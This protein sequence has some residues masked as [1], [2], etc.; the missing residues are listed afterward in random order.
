MSDSGEISRER[1]SNTLI[2]E[3]S[4]GCPSAMENL[5]TEVLPMISHYCRSRLSS[6]A[7]GRDTADDVVQETLFSIFR[8]L[9]RYVDRG[10]P[11]AAWVYGIAAHK[12][13]DAQRGVLGGA[14]PVSE[15]PDGAD[16][17]P[18]PEDH[19][20]SRADSDE[21]YGLL[22]QL[23][24]RTREVLLLRAQGMSAEKAGAQLGLSAGSVRVTYHRGVA[25]LRRLVTQPDPAH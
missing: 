18:G 6:F 17:T 22:D 11:F 15:L 24:D 9:P 13:A 10:V 3:A 4:S 5:L 20:V 21:L 25:K 23:P 2:A 12:V 19:L 14:T 16:S 8:A 7:G 1:I